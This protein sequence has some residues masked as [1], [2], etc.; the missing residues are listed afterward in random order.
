MKTEK[1]GNRTFNV[2]LITG[3][4]L[5]IVSESVRFSIEYIFWFIKRFFCRF[6]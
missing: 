4:V 3:C 2:Y 6:F 1:L 5:L